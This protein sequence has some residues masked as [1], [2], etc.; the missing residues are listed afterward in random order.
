MCSKPLEVAADADDMTRLG[1]VPGGV[2][3]SLSLRDPAGLLRIT[4]AFQ[5]DGAN[6]V[7]LHCKNLSVTGS[8]S[9]LFATASCNFAYFVLQQ[10]VDTIEEIRKF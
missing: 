3:T 4:N 6:R 8:A 10:C 7:Y 1:L 2:H 5:C 9:A